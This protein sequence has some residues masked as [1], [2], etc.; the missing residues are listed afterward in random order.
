[1]QQPTTTDSKVVVLPTRAGATRRHAEADGAV[2]NP[3]PADHVKDRGLR[4]LIILA[5][6]FAWIA[7]VAA[8]QFIFF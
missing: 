7:I 3:S 5:T 8:M 6:A 2:A 4:R 1:M